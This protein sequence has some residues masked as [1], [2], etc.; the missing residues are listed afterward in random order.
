MVVVDDFLPRIIGAD[1]AA[2][3]YDP[4]TADFNLRYYRAQ[5]RP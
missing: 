5:T 4:A 1:L 2:K 3:L